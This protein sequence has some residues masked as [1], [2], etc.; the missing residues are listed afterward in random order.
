MDYKEL[1]EYCDK[2][3]E[4]FLQEK[5]ITKE[6]YDKYKKEIIYAKRF[7]SN[8]R[9][10]HEEL[11]A[12][13][14]K[15][16]NRYIIPY[17][18]NITKTI[19]DEEFDFVEV[20]GGSSSP[21]FDSD[22]A[23]SGKE[24]V[25]NYLREK[26]GEDRVTTVG[27]QSTLGLKSACKDLLRLHK[28]DF[29]ASNDFSAILN[30]DL[31]WEENI[32]YIKSSNEPMYRFYIQNKEILDLIPQ[33]VG[34]LRQTSQH[35]GGIVI[36]DKPF[37]KYAPVDKTAGALITSYPESGQEQVLDECGLIKIDQ[38]S[39]T[40]LDTIRDTVEMVNEKL[41]LVEEDGIRKIVPQSYYIKKFVEVCANDS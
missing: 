11:M 39:I 6:Q 32:E 34:K 13:K 31:S 9:N 38:L 30:D 37:Y 7:Y 28:I 15:V 10:L 19:T 35:A 22:S 12:K 4:Y 36:T 26:F 5:F 2:Q 1:K 8:G 27:V 18:L 29:K 20:K 14:D 17:L 33:F 40:V 25:R 24:A 16:D 23:P 41:F 3:A 21:D